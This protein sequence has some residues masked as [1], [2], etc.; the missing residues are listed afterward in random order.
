MKTT[1]SSKQDVFF[2]GPVAFLFHTYDDRG[3]DTVKP[4]YAFCEH[5][6]WVKFREKFG[7]RMVDFIVGEGYAAN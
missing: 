4:I 2:P 5:E 7:P 6:A 1:K 3:F